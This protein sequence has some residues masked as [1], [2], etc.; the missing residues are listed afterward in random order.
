MKKVFFLTF[1]IAGLAVSSRSVAQVFIHAAIHIPLPVPR[2]PVPVVVAPPP[3]P[4]YYAP[5]PRYCRPVPVVVAA[6]APVYV[7]T[8]YRPRPRYYCDNVVM[9][10]ERSRGHYYRRW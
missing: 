9:V 6:P 7:R 3:P 5:A 4:V 1:L 2:I 8:Y 10:R